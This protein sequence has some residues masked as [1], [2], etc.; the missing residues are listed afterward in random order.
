MPYVDNI[1]Y[2]N[3]SLK[4][5]DVEARDLIQQNTNSINTT[6]TKVSENSENIETLQSDVSANTKDIATLQGDLATT[7]AKANKNES[8]I[9][10]L[11]KE[12]STIQGDIDSLESRATTSEAKITVL[13]SDMTSATQNIND[14]KTRM[15]SAEGKIADA[16]S[17]ITAIQAKDTEQDTKITE[18]ETKAE[19]AETDIK[20]LDERLTASTYEAGNGIYFGEGA[21]HTNIN[22]D[23]EV[24]EQINTN[25]SNISTL[26]S[27]VSGLTTRVST[28][29]T[30]ISGLKTEQEMLESRVSSN[31]SA[32]SSI[33]STITE[34]E[35]Q[36]NNKTG[37]YVGSTST[38][39]ANLRRGEGIEI[40][41][42]QGQSVS[43]IKAKAGIGIQTGLYSNISIINP[44]LKCETQLSY[45]ESKGTVGN[46][47][48]ELRFDVDFTKSGASKLNYLNNSVMMIPISP[49]YDASQ[50]FY[51]G[52]IYYLN[53]YIQPDIGIQPVKDYSVFVNGI[54][55]APSDPSVFPAPEETTAVFVRGIIRL[56]TSL[57][58]SSNYSIG[59]SSVD[60]KASKIALV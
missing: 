41:T 10:A 49:V 56:D 4:V 6:N 60:I 47:L 26:Q 37:V 17:S 42:P 58:T 46:T 29:E 34:H 54:I 2:G 25:S 32:I 30:D 20:S 14:L 23:D 21:E 11:N 45:D 39:A 59:V 55:H 27:D 43:I 53:G 18:L 5:R 44:V 24:L 51:G 36:I 38:I 1:V 35:A 52:S 12:V 31:E 13:E 22:V 40:E 3:Q 33:N 15:S 9:G 28:A 57:P 7:S 19:Q 50:P 48:T 16:E 8:D